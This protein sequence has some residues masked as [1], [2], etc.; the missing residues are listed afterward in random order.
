M[1]TMKMIG[2]IVKVAYLPHMANAVAYFVIL[3][4]ALETALQPLKMRVSDR[5]HC[6]Q[7]SVTNVQGLRTREARA[8]FCEPLR[9]FVCFLNF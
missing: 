6:S 3:H 7:T 5:R 8:Y 2:Y 9:C 4:G 1:T